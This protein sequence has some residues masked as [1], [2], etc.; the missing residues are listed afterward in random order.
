MRRIVPRRIVLYVRTVRFHFDFVSPYTYLALARSPAFAVEHGISW[1]PR[2]VLYAA[3]LDATGL[4]GPAEHGAK[5]AYTARDVVRSADRLGIPLVGPPAHPFNS[6][7]ALRT[8]CLFL[9]HPGRAQDLTVRLAAA[10]WAEGRAID[11]VDVVASVV[12]D[13]GLDPTDLAGR[14]SDP[15]AKRALREITDRA[16]ADGV[17]GVP[18]FAWDGELFWGHDRMDHLAERLSGRL[19]S[20]EERAAEIAERPRAADRPGAP[21]HGMSGPAA[22]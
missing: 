7:A 14:I 10:C 9:D 8:V 22:G 11:D 13:A 4:I 12:E 2:P 21:S 6:L 20:P 15:A 16:L 17:F 18:T 3:L 5:R 19:A 1:Q